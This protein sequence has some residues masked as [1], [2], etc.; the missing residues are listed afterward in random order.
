[1]SIGLVVA[2]DVDPQ[3]LL[4]GAMRDSTATAFDASP[5]SLPPIKYAPLPELSLYV[6]A[7][8]TVSAPVERQVNKE[9]AGRFARMIQ[10]TTQGQNNGASRSVSSQVSPTLST[11]SSNS[12]ISPILGSRSSAFRSASPA[13][14]DPTEANI[15]QGVAKVKRE[16]LDRFPHLAQYEAARPE[17]LDA[18]RP[19]IPYRTPLNIS[20]EILKDWAQ[21]SSFI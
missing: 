7:S 16:L 4:R 21:F 10:G 2:R 3:S 14:M 15:A 9:Y 18:V 1:M 8:G 19:L 12:S 17:R 11:S 20:S 13:K 5:T 6:H